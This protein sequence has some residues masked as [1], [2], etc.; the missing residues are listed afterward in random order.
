MRALVTDD[1]PVALV[2]TVVGNG[3]RLLVQVDVA[4]TRATA[5]AERALAAAAAVAALPAPRWP[6]DDL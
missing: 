3:I 1:L 2:R 6:S 5:A 4:T